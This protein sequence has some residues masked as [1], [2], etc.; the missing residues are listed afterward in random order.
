MLAYAATIFLS[1]FLLFQ[2]QPLIA[3]FILPWFGGSAAVW[4]AALL[5]FQLILLAG[6]L[7]AHCLIR[8]VKPSRQA[9]VHLALLAASVATLPIIPAARWKPS[10][11]GDPTWQI[12]LLLGATVGLPY[13][14]LSSTSPLLQAWYVRTRRG[15]VPYRMFALSNLG[16]MLALLSYP[17]LVEPALRLGTQAVT[18]SAGYGVF[19]AMCAAV[20][21]RARGFQDS[22]E[23]F[24]NAPAP[25]LATM[26]LWIGLAGCASTMLLAVTSHLTQ[27][28]APIPLLWIAPLSLYLLSFILC[29][30]RDATYNRWVFLPLLAGALGVLAWGDSM[31]ENN[32]S[33]QRMVP[34]LCAAF[35]V[36]CMVC[37]GELA[38]SK[39]HPKY[40]TQFYLMISAGGAAG[41]LFVALI[42]PRLFQDY[43]ELPVAMVASVALVTWA[44]WTKAPRWARAALVLAT[45]G[46]GGVMA[47]A[48]V[49]KNRGYLL[50]ARNFYGV[51]RVRDYAADKSGPGVRTLIHGTIN[52]GTQLLMAG[53]DR[54]PT[55]YFGRE[56][57]IS[58]AIQ[59]VGQRGPIRIGVLGLGAGVTASLA[60]SGDVI[61]Y[62]EINPL[63]V[64]IANREFGFY[65]GCPAEKQVYMGDGRLVLERLPS[66][67]L[68]LLAMDAFSSDVQPVHLLTTE[69]YIT[70]Q[71]HL[72][73]DGIL[74]VHISNRYLDLEP[75]VAAAATRLGWPGIVVT[76]EGDEES[77]Y[78]AS[79]WVLVSPRGRIFEKGIFQ[80]ASV[81]R[82]R[83]NP[84]IR[85]WTDD[86]SNILQILK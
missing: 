52:H 48:E 46:F 39:P 55:S 17:V 70:Y 76:D 25:T 56:S 1:A 75:I 72:K 20:G 5:F 50:S 22:G 42:A 37:H 74:A 30:E 51:L 84:K 35:F 80:D 10:G 32:G 68:D 34:A 9:W 73:P 14:L 2:V 6:Y 13:L 31:Y 24:E 41:G 85:A 81:D 40:L 49:T 78:S 45:L 29:F 69:A 58:R 38:R 4:S 77:Y 23:A 7:Y 28:V 3:K 86:Y 63:I 43:L 62:Y 47:R 19:A 66:E 53:S 61:H 8:Y 64:E 82:L 16:S 65:R 44:L 59:A 18:W 57:G 12:M 15:A 21:W 79:T 60:R 54:I 83:P 11:S 33:V 26:L 67:N 27:N 36:C 71:R